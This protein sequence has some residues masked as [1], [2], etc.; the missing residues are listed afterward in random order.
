MLG[1]NRSHDSAGQSFATHRA[2]RPL[3]QPG[4]AEPLTRLAAFLDAARH[5]VL[6]EA[7]T[8]SLTPL[9]AYPTVDAPTSSARAPTSPIVVGGDG[10]MLSIAAPARAVRRCPL[11]G[12]NQGRLGFLTDIALDDME[13]ALAAMLDG[14]LRRGARTL[15]RAHADPRR[16]CASAAMLA[17]NDVVVNRGAC[18]GMIDLAVDDRRR[19]VYAM[20]C[21]GLIVATPTGS[22]AY[23]L[24]ASGPI[25]IRGA[26]DV[27][28]AGLAARA[29]QPADRR[30]ATPSDR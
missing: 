22:T 16:R 18:G 20:R 6:L 24:S 25:V 8:A 3:Q 4:I 15:L 21:D 19:F 12:I 26:R 11:I 28:G 13:A 27:A 5:R 7:D 29:D 30:R 2:R 9:P 17:F 10:T 14:A 23:A 1:S